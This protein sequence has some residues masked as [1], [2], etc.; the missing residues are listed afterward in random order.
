MADYYRPDLPAAKEGQSNV[1]FA[2]GSP[3]FNGYFKWHRYT[4]G[5]NPSSSTEGL[6]APADWRAPED[7]TFSKKTGHWYTPGEMQNAGYSR[8]DGEWLHPNDIRQR[9]VDRQNAEFEAKLARRKESEGRMRKVH[10]LGRKK[11]IL[12]GPDGAAGKATISKEFLN[13]S[14]GVMK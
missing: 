5:T 6:T 4:Y 8:I 13:R 3:G 10:A 2:N 9:E 7:W 12:T 1:W 11:T 14:K